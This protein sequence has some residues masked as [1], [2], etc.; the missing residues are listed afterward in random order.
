MLCLSLSLLTGCGQRDLDKGFTCLGLGDY[1]Q[2]ITFFKIAVAEKPA[3]YPARLG[4][5]QALLQ[6]A[7]AETD[8]EAFKYGLIQLEACRTLKPSDDLSSLLSNAWFDRARM[9][10]RAKDTLAA[11]EALGKASERN[12]HH[13]APL[14]LAGVL[15]GKRG[16]VEQAAALFRKAL[17][18]DS[19]DASAHFNLGMIHWQSDEFHEAHAH[20]LQAL[21]Q[22]PDDEDILYWFARAESRLRASP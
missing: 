19:K 2:A 3:S 21:S 8:S 13:A 14:N 18:V 11:L 6:K 17:A 4:L 12:P 10:A 5:G 1:P 15:Y 7:V 9:H 22:L 20:W 16:E